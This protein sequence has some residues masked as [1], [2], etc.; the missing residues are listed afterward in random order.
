MAS[1]GSVPVWSHVQV[2]GCGSRLTL[3]PVACKAS[4]NSS[5]RS[6][7][8]HRVQFQRGPE[9]VRGKTHT[10]VSWS[11]P[12]PRPT[13]CSCSLHPNKGRCAPLLNLLDQD[14]S[15]PHIDVQWNNNTHPR[16]ADS[17]ETNNV[18]TQLGHFH[19]WWAES[20]WRGIPC[21]VLWRTGQR[22]CD[23]EGTGSVEMTINAHDLIN[24]MSSLLC[25]CL[26]LESSSVLEESKCALCIGCGKCV[27]GWE[28]LAR[29]CLCLEG[30]MPGGLTNYSV[31]PVTS[32][33]FPQ[34]L[35]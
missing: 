31:P 28:N 2:A 26:K 21:L 3:V 20:L 23:G 33:F 5:L 7:P 16:A 9:A 35:F 22:L 13:A 1:N 14:Q 30:M 17:G 8:P 10:E 29:H 11:S 24:V 25:V 12:T 18:H 19:A 34:C 15:I 32:T 6:R 4:R 27:N